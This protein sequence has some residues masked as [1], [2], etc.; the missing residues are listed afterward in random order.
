[1]KKRIFTILLALALVIGMV[2][3]LATPVSAAT[4]LIGL[5]HFDNNLLDSSGNAHPGTS[6][7]V[8]ATY[9]SGKFAGGAVA[10]NGTTRVS[11]GNLG[12]FPTTG[13]IEFWMNPSVVENWRNPFTTNYNGG[14][15]G[16]RFEE[17]SNFGGYTN[18][19]YVVI[20]DG[21]GYTVGQYTAT[22]A[23]Y[24]K[25]LVPGT[26][27]HVGLIWDKGANNIK[28]FLDGTMVFDLANTYWP[29][30]L[31]NVAVGTGYSTDPERQWK[32]RVDE[33]RIWNTATPG[34]TIAATPEVAFNPKGGSHTITAT[35]T[36]AASG[37][38][39]TFYVTGP[40]TAQDETVLTTA[41]GI[42]VKTINNLVAG[43]DYI[44]VTIDGPAYTEPPCRVA[45]SNVLVRKYW[46][47]NY[48]TGGGTWDKPDVGK[49]TDFTFA[50]CVGVDVV[51]GIVGQFNI[52]NHMTNTTYHSTGF[53]FLNFFGENATTPTASNQ[54]T[55]FTGTF[56]DSRDNSPITLT[57]Y[58][59]ENV[60]PGEGN[61]G[62][63]AIA[64]QE[65]TAFGTGAFWIGYNFENATYLMFVTTGNFQIHNLP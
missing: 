26:W 44:V 45:P 48:I 9:G 52:V 32:G 56:R 2:F 12:S 29:A 50:G 27:Y 60:I 6:L 43:L 63:D 58:I 17:H 41:S 3:P 40:D 65:G 33:V 10:F 25:P 5:W 42:A 53:E 11:I 15:T 24:N 59:I 49:K 16:I 31:P 47:E 64:I 54:C 13:T 30:T 23:P 34:F 51:D 21:A 36:P 22:E 35:V 1:M 28:G 57:V 14:N 61:K 7:P 19:F 55:Y 62:L 4:P 46:L 39:V 20:G 18:S 8:A 38:P 37:I